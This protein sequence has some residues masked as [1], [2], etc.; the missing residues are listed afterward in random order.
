MPEAE[1][2]FAKLLAAGPIDFAAAIRFN[3][4]ETGRI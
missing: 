2:F 4:A 1:S 3:A